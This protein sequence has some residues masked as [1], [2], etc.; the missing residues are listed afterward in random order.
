MNINYFSF[1]TLKYILFVKLEMLD[2]SIP[3]YY[4]I[5]NKIVFTSIAITNE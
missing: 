1:N 4:F 2:Y 3:Q 5:P